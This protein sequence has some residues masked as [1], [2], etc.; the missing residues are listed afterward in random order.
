MSISNKL[1][2]WFFGKYIGKDEIGNKY[3][4]NS[5]NFSKKSTKRWVIF[6]Q[7]I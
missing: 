2:T 4:A 7:K 5:L 6:H 3:Y 1:Y